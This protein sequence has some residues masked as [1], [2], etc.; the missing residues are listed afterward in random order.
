MTDKPI[1]GDVRATDYAFD[2]FD[3]LNWVASPKGNDP[4]GVQSDPTNAMS[5]G[6]WELLRTMNQPLQ[7]LTVIGRNALGETVTETIKLRPRVLCNATADQLRGGSVPL[8]SI[9]VQ[10]LPPHDH[11]RVYEIEAKSDTLAAQE[12][13]RRFVEEMEILADEQQAD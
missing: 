10:G 1:Q 5:E 4:M 11:R 13:I 8:W 6:A 12:G 9:E 3:G 2:V 7:N